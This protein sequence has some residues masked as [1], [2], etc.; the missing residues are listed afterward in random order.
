MLYKIIRLKL[1]I[2]IIASQFLIGCGGSDSGEENN[3]SFS[4]CCDG[5]GFYVWDSEGFNHWL[6]GADSQWKEL[7]SLS[8]IEISFTSEQIN[9]IRDGNDQWVIDLLSEAHAN[10]VEVNLLLGDSTWI[11]PQHRQSLIGLI[12]LFSDYQFDRLHLD[13]EPNQLETNPSQELLAQFID[14]LT[15][16]VDVSPWPVTLSIHPCNLEPGDDD[17]SDAIIA[18]G[19]RELSVMIYTTNPI[20]IKN[21]F[22]SIVENHSEV[23]F[24]LAVSVEPL[25]VSDSEW[26]DMSKGQWYNILNDILAEVQAQNFNHLIVQSW[27]DWQSVSD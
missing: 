25:I 27:S 21:R 24:S 19:V 11:Y 22:N 26:E 13:I 6:S 23:E 3:N 5:Y 18:S 14:T 10:D 20:T 16:A 9:D 12:G 8:R 4:V 17:I 2:V 7:P 1:I 15:A